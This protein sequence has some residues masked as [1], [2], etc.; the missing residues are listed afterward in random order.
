LLMVLVMVVLML[1]ALKARRAGGA[2]AV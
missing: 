2:E 1:N